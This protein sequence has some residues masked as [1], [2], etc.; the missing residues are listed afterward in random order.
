MKFLFVSVT[1]IF[2]LV[3]CGGED[4]INPEG[5]FPHT[6]NGLYW[7]DKV[8]DKSY[9]EAVSYCKSIGGRLPSIGEL[10]TLVIN[11]PNMET[12]GECGIN[13]S[14][15]SYSD[16]PEYSCKGCSIDYNSGKYS[17]LGF[18]GKFWSSS[19]ATDYVAESAWTV[20]FDTAYF[21]PNTLSQSSSVLCVR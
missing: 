10:R 17:A 1:L 16:C 6:N 11:C 4:S 13:N 19:K 3:N 9:D 7:S 12:D 14:C 21:T 20:D 8:T 2:V 18:A 15:L 5:S